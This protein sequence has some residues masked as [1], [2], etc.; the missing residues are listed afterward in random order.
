MLSIFD[1]YSYENNDFAEIFKNLTRYVNLTIILLNH[2][3]QFI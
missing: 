2:P 3:K 1:I